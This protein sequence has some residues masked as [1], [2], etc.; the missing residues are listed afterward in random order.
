MTATKRHAD[1]GVSP[2]VLLDYCVRVSGLPWQTSSEIL[3][4][5]CLI[6]DAFS[7]A[8]ILAIRRSRD[9]WDG[10]HAAEVA[11][12][13]G[14][15]AQEVPAMQG[16]WALFEAA[17]IHAILPRLNIPKL[18]CRPAYMVNLVTE[19]VGR[20]LNFFLFQICCR[21]SDIHFRLQ[22]SSRDE[23]WLPQC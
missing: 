7:P 10:F 11:Y 9:F 14:V 20:S 21:Y 2:H 6:P 13:M 16:D 23:G 22:F 8:N 19:S 15:A 3:Y 1:A 12:A 4:E 17:Q 18:Y 5:R